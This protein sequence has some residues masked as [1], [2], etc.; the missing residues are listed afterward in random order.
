MEEYQGAKDRRKERKKKYSRK[1]GNKDYVRG[2]V[3]KYIASRKTK[4][5]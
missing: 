5:W 2:G 3:E 1:I 4:I